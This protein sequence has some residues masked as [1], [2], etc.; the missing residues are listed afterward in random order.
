MKYAFLLL[1]A[2]CLLSA[3]SAQWLEETIWLPDSF[4]W[5]LDPQCLVCDSANNTVYV[6]GYGDY[7]FAIDGATNRK[8]A[9][10][11]VR[12]A[13]ALCYNPTNNKV[14]CANSGSASVTV[15]DGATNAVLATAAASG[16]PCALCYNATTNKI[17]CA[18]DSWNLTVI[19]GATNSVVADF[20]AG[21]RPCAL[22]YNATDNKVYSANRGGNY[23]T[24]IDGAT[25]GVITVVHADT[26]PIALS[27][28][29]AG[30]KVYCANQ[31]SGN[32]TVI[33][34]AT[35]VALG[36][37]EVGAG[38]LDLALNPAQNRVYV[39]NFDGSSI[40]VL[41][42]SAGGV[43]EDFKPQA[44]SQKPTPTVAHGVLLLPE[45]TSRKPQAS[46][47]MDAA[48]RKVLNVSPGVNDVSRLAPGVYFVRGP[49]TGGGRPDAAVTKVVITG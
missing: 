2:G 49:E 37:I 17:Y 21:D 38:P 5:P 12:S 42:D 25:D 26:T 35:D 6:G 27:Y 39:A 7:V 28:D 24:V 29:P 36:A 4:S 33:D 41:R 3:A 14:Y 15:I 31:T 30:D 46:S 45:A 11:P 34:G 44:T 23:V 48:G 40:S 20:A 32:V 18:S 8:V 1:A 13:G 43:E 9:R 10:I 47:L 22:C 16:W 19:D